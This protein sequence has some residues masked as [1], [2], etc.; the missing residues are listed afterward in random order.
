MTSDR[1]QILT[2]KIHDVIYAGGHTYPYRLTIDTR[3][4]I[5][6]VWPPV[7]PSGAE[8]VVAV[9]G[10]HLPGGELTDLKINGTPLWRKPHFI[11][12]IT[13]AGPSTGSAVA[14]SA[15]DTQW[16]NGIDGNILRLAICR[17]GVPIYRE[18]DP[19]TDDGSQ[20]TGPFTVAGHFPLRGQ[21]ITIRFFAQKD[22]IRHIE[23]LSHRL[24]VPVNSILHI[25]QVT[26]ADD[27]SET[28]KLL[29]TEVDGRQNPGGNQLPTVTSD[30]AYRLTA[31]AEGI[32]QLRIR[33]RY[34]G[35]RVRPDRFF[36]VDVH[37]PEP[38]FELIA[39]ESIASADGTA[40][41][42]T[43]AVSIRRGGHYEIPVY[44]IRE[45]GHDSA[46]TVTAKDLPQ[47]VTCALT[48]IAAGKPGTKLL[49]QAA[50]DA[51]EATLPIRITG[52]AGNLQ[53]EAHVATLLS[54]GINGLPRTARLTHALLLN[55]MKDSQ[56]FTVKF[57]LTEAIMH[58][59]QQLLI[60]VTLTR[61]QGFNGKVDVVFA[62]QPGNVDVPAVSL[63]ARRWHSNRSFVLQR[64]CCRWPCAI[65]GLCHRACQVSSKSMVGRASTRSR[66]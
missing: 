64:K 66:R 53:K 28:I 13:A 7:V 19:I 65:A 24:G 25:E 26:T 43:G 6:F 34:A 2:V 36:V 40:P 39:F 56:P 42:T 47:G 49:L 16:W 18:S 31:P 11:D 48:T 23:V 22:E 20:L 14:A 51:P 59:D 4:L 50:D 46:I 17:G 55:V 60:P 57:G 21:D 30:A 58:Q 37:A 29:A 3:P 32:Y 12:A 41:V 5:D 44:V 1:D 38:D 8:T 62:G 63:C 54:N 33:D 27:G 45:D 10:R 9:Y 35:T 15:I 52:T 61:R